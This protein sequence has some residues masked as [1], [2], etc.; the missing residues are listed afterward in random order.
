[1]SQKAAESPKPA[2]E[3]EHSPARAGGISFP[4]KD[5]RERIERAKQARQ[6]ARIARR[7][8]PLTFRTSYIIPS[9]RAQR[10]EAQETISPL[11]DNPLLVGDRGLSDELAAP[12]GKLGGLDAERLA[13]NGVQACA[14]RA[15]VH[16]R[17]GQ[18]F[19]VS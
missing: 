13:D 10:P 4:D 8:K 15:V 5:W 7:G 3:S 6:E 12:F 17:P 14:D 9:N 18:K 19:M 1:M 2:L 16:L 11:A